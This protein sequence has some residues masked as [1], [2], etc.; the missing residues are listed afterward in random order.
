ML[1]DILAVGAHPDD[2]ELFAG[3][4]LA[5]MA[6]LG[7]ATG[8]VDATRGELGTR[9][10]PAVRAKEAAAAAA[11]LKA[12][13]RGN[14]RLPDGGVAVTPAARLKL[15]KVLRRYRPRIVMTHYWEDAHPDHVHTS[16]LV[17]EAVHH[18]GLA[19]IVTGRERHR[20][21]V[22]LYFRLPLGMAPS[23]VVDVSDYGDVRDAAI[24]AHRSQLYDPGGGGLET[25]VSRPDFL[26]HVEGVHS[27]YGTMIGKR[28]GEAFHYRETLEVRDLCAHFFGA[29]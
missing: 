18:A 26:S 27:F 22:V 8:I 15:I 25:V 1:L 13:V 3:G 28:K 21:P 7:Y 2:V 14:L 9:G 23:F 17:T 24:A 10:T 19:K 16:R 5:K 11:I 29:K 4:T 6:A 12:K 20:P